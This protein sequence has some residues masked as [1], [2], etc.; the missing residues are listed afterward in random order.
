LGPR[1]AAPDIA[2][3]IVGNTATGQL[4]AT[5]APYKMDVTPDGSLASNDL[6]AHRFEDLAN[7]R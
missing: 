4:T 7:D 1:L 3:E 6:H 5:N 2:R